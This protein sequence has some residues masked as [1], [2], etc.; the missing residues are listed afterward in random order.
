MNDQEMITIYRD[1]VEKIYRFFFYKVLDRET[2]ED[3]T[4]TT[5][6]TFA[7]KSVSEK[8]DSPK[9]YLFGIAKNIFL[10][11]LKGKYKAKIESIDDEAFEDIVDETVELG[12]ERKDIFDM[13]Q[14]LLPQVPSKQREV[15]S[16]R[17][18]EKLS[19]EEISQRLGKDKNY[20]TTTQRRGLRS[21]KRLMYSK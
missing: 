19:I 8:V 15:L 18:I 2:A 16:L 1:N 12:P 10:T 13:L 9:S 17:F 7:K 6:L 14:E 11:F 21:L 5:F 20:V 3:L 4:S